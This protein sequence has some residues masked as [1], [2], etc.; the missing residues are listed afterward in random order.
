MTFAIALLVY[1]GGGIFLVLDCR[2]HVIILHAIYLV[3]TNLEIQK[4]KSWL[5]SSELIKLDRTQFVLVKH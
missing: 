1:L 5:N 3:G 2:P 4:I